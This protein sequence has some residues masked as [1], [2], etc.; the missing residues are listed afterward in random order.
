[1][2]APVVRLDKFKGINN[3][4]D[5]TDVPKGYLVDVSN[6][7]VDNSGLLIQK[8]GYGFVLNA[9]IDS[10]WSDNDRCFAV[11]DGNLVEV[12]DDYT[13]TQLVASVGY[14]P[15]SFCHADGN[16][17][18]TSDNANGK[19]SGASATSFGLD[20]VLT[21]PTLAEI[22][23]SLESGRY[24]IAITHMDANGFESG[25][26]Y[27][28]L[29]TLSANSKG[30][31]ITNI[32][33]STNPRV[34]HTA[35]YVSDRNGEKVYRRTVLL[36]GVTTKSYT[37]LPVSNTLLRSDRLDKA[38]K[39]TIIKYFYGRVYIVNGQLIYYS[40]GKDY[41][42]FDLRNYL[43]YAANV[44]AILPCEDGMWVAADGLYWINGK[45]PKQ[46]N[47]I[48][49]SDYRIYHNSD[50]FVP[51]HRFSNKSYYGYGYYATCKEGILQLG[52]NGYFQL[53]SSTVYNIPA[54]VTAA[55]SAIFEYL[56]GYYYVSMLE[57]QNLV[58][59]TPGAVS[60]PTIPTP[61]PPT[62]ST[63]LLVYQDLIAAENIDGYKVVITSPEGA[64]N[65]DA[66]N[67]LHL[68]RVIGITRQAYVAGDTVRVY[69]SGVVSNVNWNF[70][71]SIGV[72]F[73]DGS[74]NLIQDVTG[75]A[76]DQ[77]IGVA[78]EPTK[79]LLNLDQPIQIGQ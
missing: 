38:P 77:R 22:S 45:D 51:A 11:A 76:I 21:S 29:I 14:Y 54:G 57:P 3:R 31:S 47:Q 1:M 4:F 49:K 2:T 62:E 79:L 40:E 48:K 13:T 5:E 36:N 60:P 64:R 33:V 58:G 46:F 78:I 35:I 39:G 30:I 18:Y 6:L 27:R 67:L 7:V 10:L 72:V 63:N 28:A 50:N 41:E 55:N 74:A 8:P 24:Q 34:T 66:N 69:Y 53:V 73:G 59:W 70:N 9:Q 15:A 20:K 61:T 12:N 19:I 75:L 42:H 65:F 68:N 56:N 52:N 43:Y 16:Y 23:G 71:V 44:T 32:P 17:Y 37:T 25:C 26:G